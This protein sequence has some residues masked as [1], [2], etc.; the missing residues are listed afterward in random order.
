[1]RKTGLEVAARRHKNS[2]ERFRIA[3]PE[4]R[5]ALLHSRGA[6]RGN[7]SPDRSANSDGLANGHF[8]SLWL[9]SLDRLAHAARHRAVRLSDFHD[10]L[11]AALHARLLSHAD[12]A[13]QRLGPWRVPACACDPEHPLGHRPNFRRR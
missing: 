7:E 2:M 12:V 8:I 1:M 13:S 10:Q 6:R 4:E 3:S 11:W 9:E 5:S